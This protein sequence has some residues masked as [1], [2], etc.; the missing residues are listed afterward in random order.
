MTFLASFQSAYSLSPLLIIIVKTKVNVELDWNHPS[1]PLRS[2]LANVTQICKRVEMADA[3]ISLLS[4]N[5]TRILSQ[6]ADLILGVEDEVKSLQNQLKLTQ[7]YLQSFPQKRNDQA[8][9]VEFIN[10]V[11]NAAREAED[12]IDAYV[13]TVYRQ[14]KESFLFRLKGELVRLLARRRA[15]EEIKAIN[16]RFEEIFKNK[17]R[18][19]IQIGDQLPMEDDSLMRRRRLIIEETDV[20]G[21]D[22]DADIIIDRLTKG[23]DQRDVV[24]IVGMGGI[25]KTT[26][27]RKVYNHPVVA[28]NFD[29]RA[30]V[31][32][33]QGYRVRDL[34]QAIIKCAMGLSVEDM[35]EMGEDELGLELRKYLRSTRYLIVLDDVWRTEFWEELN[36]VFAKNNYRSRIIITTR[37][38]EVALHVN[39]SSSPYDLHFLSE[40]ES[41]E[42]FSRKVF[43]EG[44]QCPADLEPLGKQMAHECG[45]LPLAIVVLA[46][47]LLK[48]EKT[49]RWWSKVSCSV[50]SFVTEHTD[51][52]LELSYDN[53]PHHLRPCF[54]YFGLFPKDFEIPAR[55]L[56]RLWIAEGFVE[57]KDGETMEEVG[58]DYLEDFIARNLIQ[59][60]KRRFDGTIKTCCI[61]DLLH[62]LCIKKAKEDKFLEVLGHDCSSLPLNSR[63]LGLHSNILKHISSTP[64]ATKLR[65]ILCFGL[66]ERQLSSNEWK[67]LYKSF[68]LLRVLDVWGVGVEAIPNEI[69]KLI[70]QRYLRLK[71]LT[72]QTLPASI[73]N[74]WNLQTLEVIAPCIDRPR[75]DIWKMQ[76][77]R[78]LYFHGQ[79]VL[80]EPPILKAKDSTANVLSNVLTLSCISPDSCKESVFSMLPNLLKLGINGDLEEHRTNLTLKNLSKLNHLQTLKL[81]RDRRCEELINLR[82]GIKF[83]PNLTKLTLLETQLLEDPMDVLGRLPNLQVLKLK[84]AAYGGRD[85]CCSGNGFPKLQVL[86]LLNLA[87]RC[88]TISEGSMP[89]LRSVVINRCGNLEGLPSALPNIPAF[90]ELELW[91]P[92]VSLVKEAKEIEM[93][94]GKEKFK[95]V[96]YQW[97]LGPLNAILMAQ[98][99]SLD[100]HK[101]VTHLRN[102]FEVVA[103]TGDGT[104]DAPALHEADIGLAMGIA[105]TE[106]TKE[107]A[108]VIILDDNFKTIVNVAKWGRAVDINIQKFVQFQLTVNVV[109]LVINFVSAC[110]SGSA[111]LTAVQLLWANLIFDT[112]GAL[113]LA[114]EPPNDRLMNRPPVGRGVSF[115]TNAMWRNIIG[116]SIYQLAVLGTFNFDGKNLLRLEGS[117][118]SDVLT[119]FIFNTFVFC[120][121]FNEINSRDM[122]KINVFRG[123]FKSWVFIAVMVSTVTFQVIIVE[124]LGS[125]VALFH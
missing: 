11:R 37:H 111:P 64:S 6:Q 63:R 68:P 60:S 18:F 112:L 5:L 15:A 113:A 118:T 61:H 58:E 57:K 122:E 31:Y 33:S 67:L 26:L 23:D 121:V 97:K 88:W 70:H 36:Q 77:L 53:L 115:I 72:A 81:E 32:V 34:L 90:E 103:V 109:A 10:Q 50:S 100:K 38:K 74:L 3:V 12:T 89:S 55:Q 20:V 9:M 66:D 75:I 54:L 94:P 91:S 46:G 14:R 105:G 84:N 4:S 8:I 43:P 80:P 47:V 124:F 107:N 99:L 87:I 104:N 39:P 49:S 16:S 65:S 95:L 52:I 125:F 82:Y 83:P 98:S 28:E 30:W 22:T 45:G 69:D 92:H 13:A 102:M 117:D 7:S 40:E 51:R 78:H 71:S 41:W 56:V 42:L 17:E 114:T 21:F 25:G 116:Q 101:L 123:M 106:V 76:E 35:K 85:L 29:F 93:S 79:A 1:L 73:C 96:I 86:K 110:I 24:P 2:Q 44:R 120:Q 27:A 19:D 108:D 59:V 48:K 62:D 119:T